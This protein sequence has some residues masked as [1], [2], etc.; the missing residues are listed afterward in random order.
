MLRGILEHLSFTWIMGVNPRIA[1][2][3][4]GAFLLG[5]AYVG[6][7]LGWWLGHP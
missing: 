2:A 5:L 1:A 3:V 6:Q 7:L 4:W